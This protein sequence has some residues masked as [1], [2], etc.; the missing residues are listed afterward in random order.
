MHLA[1][2]YQLMVG[3]KQKKSSITMHLLFYSKINFTSSSCK[4]PENKLTCCVP[5]YVTLT[6]DSFIFPQKAPITLVAF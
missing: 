2:G 5:E 1:F 6:L 4:L 3:S